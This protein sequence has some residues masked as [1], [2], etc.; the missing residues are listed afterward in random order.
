MANVDFDKLLND[1]LSEINSRLPNPHDDPTLEIK[2]E[3]IENAAQV[4][5]EI[6][7]R[8]EELKEPH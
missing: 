2:K 5:V 3:F 7:K 1:Y 4:C 6:L 8:Y